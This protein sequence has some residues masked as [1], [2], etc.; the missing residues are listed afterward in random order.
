MLLLNSPQTF[1]PVAKAHGFAAVM[2]AQDDDDWT[3][4]V[5]EGD[6]GMGR[7]NVYDEDGELVFKGMTV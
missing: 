3:Y 7:I 6:N 5:V 2:N 1:Y 4:S